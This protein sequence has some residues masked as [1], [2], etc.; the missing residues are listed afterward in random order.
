MVI[1]FDTTIKEPVPENTIKNIWDQF[2]DSGYRNTNLAKVYNQGFL[3]GT[4]KKATLEKKY[5]TPNLPNKRPYYVGQ[6][7]SAKVPIGGYGQIVRDQCGG[8]VS[9][10]I[11]YGGK[12][13]NNSS[14][15][16]RMSDFISTECSGGSEYSNVYNEYTKTTKNIKN[17]N[18]G[19]ESN[20][21]FIGI[22]QVE[23]N[24]GERCL[25]GGVH[26]PSFCQLGDYINTQEKC[27]DH[28]KGTRSLDPLKTFCHYAKDRLCGKQVGDQLKKN[29]FDVILKSDRNYIREPIC[30][31]YCGGPGETSSGICKSHKRDY[32]TRRENWPDAG[33][34]CYDYWKANFNTSEMNDAC[35]DKLELS[36]SPENITTGKGC[37][38]LCEGEGLDINESY[39]NMR[40]LGYC[41][42]NKNNM[43]TNYCFNFC[44]DHPDLCETY[45]NEYC[46]GKEDKLDQ[47]V[48][49][50]GKKVSDYCG[51]FLGTDYYDKYKDEIFK[52]FQQGGYK[53]EGVSN[54]RSEPECIFPECKSGSILT[55]DQRNNIPNCGTNCVQVMLNDF[56][57]AQVNG[58]YLASQSANCTNIVKTETGDTSDNN[59]N[60]IIDDSSSDTI[61]DSSSD[62]IS[63]NT[64]DNINIIIGSVCGI[65][66]LICIVVMVVIIR[67]ERKS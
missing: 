57:N 52:Q 51:C 19:D 67:K 30:T 16:Q 9:N 18:N 47:K 6:I 22:P 31:D 25:V 40:R 4:D 33:E 63:S 59:S 13:A 10:S 36:S 48:G 20:Q 38:K 2:K 53:I 23:V 45:L 58:D 66:I 15:P 62:T 46:K 44:K 64:S 56:N 27:Q 1:S 21:C 65:I 8:R 5:K 60:D 7:S 37:G 41:T 24:D 35:K 32:C 11:Y 3:D 26:Y 12:G 28:C 54:I 39:C 17:N 50:E 43:E 61:D 55:S 14:F 42:A 29:G 34:Y 49:V